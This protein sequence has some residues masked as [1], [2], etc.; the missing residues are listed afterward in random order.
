MSIYGKYDLTGV[1]DGDPEPCPRVWDE[2]KHM[3]SDQW[4]DQ[5]FDIEVKN[6]QAKYETMNYRL[7]DRLADPKTMIELIDEGINN[8]ELATNVIAEVLE[9]LYKSDKY[10][11]LI[12]IDNYNQWYQPT[13]FPSFRYENDRNLSGFIPPHDLA[14][15]RLFM[16]F[17]G[18]FMRNG[19]KLFATSHRH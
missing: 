16:R 3:W 11:T 4:K 15:C 18:H 17:D 12:T 13:R 9:Q 2:K 8:P 6:L 7:S 10:K 19:F 14:L 1:K 5:L